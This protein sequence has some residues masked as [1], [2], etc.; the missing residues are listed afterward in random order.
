M[1]RHETWV[2]LLKRS[3][4]VIPMALV[5]AG[6][7]VWTMYGGDPTHSNYDSSDVITTGNAS[8]LTEAGT[9][10]PATGTNSWI[11]SSPTVASNDMLYA[12]AN[13]ADAGDCAGITDPNDFPGTDG[14]PHDVQDSAAPNECA[15]TTGELYAYSASGGTTNC[16]TPTLGNPTL[17]CQ[18][19]WTAIP[20]QAHGLTTSPA[21]DTSLSTPVVYVGTHGGELYAYNASNG[22]LLWHSQTLGG[23]IEG[24]LTIANGYIYVPEDYGWVYV[25]PSTT[26][27]KGNDQNCWF[28]KSLGI[29]ECDPDWGYSTGGNN[30]STP[31]VANGMMYQAAGDHVG[32]T[33]NDPD[34][35]A[36]Y[37]FNASYEASECPGTYA[38][39]E[40]GKPLKDIATCTPAWSAPWKYGGE[41]NGGGSSPSVANGDV[42]IESLSDGLLAYSANGSSN[43][44]GTQY[45]GQWGAICTPLWVAATG[46]DY[47]GGAD[48]GPTPAVANGSVYVGNRAGEVYAFNATTGTLEWS[49]ATGGAIDSS[50]AIA[51]D[52]A[53]DAVAFVGCSTGVSG[54][55]CTNSLFAL[56]AATGGPALWTANTD[57]SVDNPPIVVDNG[58]GS[59]TG[60]AY[61]TSGNQ[62]FAYALPTSS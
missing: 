41:W 21:V 25:F 26:G 59:G 48:A 2:Q 51:G 8:T 47:S 40:S 50:V 17:N 6:C 20:S 45:V 33:M 43:C 18:P 4:L 14:D 60:A 31:A 9:T 62:V 11:T 24:S 52:S 12:T 53:S 38:P 55:T 13:Y 3:A 19:V 1:V 28:A 46:K 35:Y 56:D 37:G 61:V 54:Q 7:N 22:T 44:T 34:Q 15:D 58:A 39:H 32:T 27:T 57:G 23:S 16:P 5:L 10:A 36:V 42:Y 29:T 30:F 49:F